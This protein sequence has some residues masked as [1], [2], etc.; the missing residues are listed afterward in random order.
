VCCGRDVQS[1]ASGGFLA[2]RQR[3]QLG[4]KVAA[5]ADFGDDPVV[6]KP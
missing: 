4:D 2:G 6:V 1:R 5:E 3:Q